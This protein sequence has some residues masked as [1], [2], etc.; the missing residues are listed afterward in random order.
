[1]RNCTLNYAIY[2]INKFEKEFGVDLEVTWISLDPYSCF[3]NSA[4]YY[5]CENSNESTIFIPKTKC[6][7]TL[8]EFV[9]HEMAHALFRKYHISAALKKLIG[10]WHSS[11][12]LIY[13]IRIF[14]SHFKTRGKGFCSA[15]SIV[16]GEEEFAELLSFVLTNRRKKRWFYFS[17]EVIDIKSDP[18]L[19]KKV[20][21]VKSSLGLTI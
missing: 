21:A 12:F 9:Y 14:I 18:L 16:D 20:K 6:K 11:N 7:R 19:S 17:G 13:N 5:V 2:L 10:P 4:G 15:Y 1:M 8:K 3:G